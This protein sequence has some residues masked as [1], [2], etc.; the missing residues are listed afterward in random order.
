MSASE[1]APYP[2]QLLPLPPFLL[3]G[4]VSDWP[5]IL[6]GLT[7]TGHFLMRDIVTD[8]AEPVAESRQRLVERLRRAAGLA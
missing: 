5:D 4:G 8:R 1:A 2:G 3:E 6:D 7:L